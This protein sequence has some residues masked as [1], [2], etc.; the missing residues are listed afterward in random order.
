[1]SN[2]LLII[3]ITS[4]SHPHAHASMGVK[5]KGE[6]TSHVNVLTTLTI[7]FFFMFFSLAC[8]LQT[9]LQRD[10]FH[11]LCCC[12]VLWRGTNSYRQASDIE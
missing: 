11:L 8:L 2:N 5:K 1:M 4:L 7:F 12:T 3:I 9:L 6:W 10:V